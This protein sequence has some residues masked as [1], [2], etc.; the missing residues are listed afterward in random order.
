MSYNYPNYNTGSYDEPNSYF[1]DDDTDTDTDT[2]DYTSSSG[3]EEDMRYGDYQVDEDGE[4][5]LLW[6]YFEDEDE[7]DDNDERPAYDYE[8]ED[9]GPENDQQSEALG[10]FYWLGGV[11]LQRRWDYVACLTRTYMVVWDDSDEVF[12][13]YPYFTL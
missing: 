1:S 6:Q 8:N 10:D 13:Y 11:R 4:G 3:D 5:Y 7:D 9:A 2:S 12:W